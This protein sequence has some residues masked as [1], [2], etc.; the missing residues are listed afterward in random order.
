MGKARISGNNAF[1]YVT[2][3]SGAKIEIG[4]VDKFSAKKADEL[5]KAK[6][7]GQ[8]GIT[9]WVEH[10]G[11]ELS[12]E[13]GKVDFKL[14]QMLHAQDEQ[15]LKGGRSPYFKV[16]ERIEYMNGDIEEW[17][18]PEVS[19]HGYEID[20][21]SEELSEKFSGF[22]GVN[23]IATQSSTV[24]TGSSTTL[25]NKLLAAMAPKPEA[26]NSDATPTNG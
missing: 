17:E 22:C 11:W 23:R 8:K 6:P 18:Y 21:P 20:V 14:A 26:S 12:F 15:I 13:G 1:I 2:D 24:D 10:G 4:E 3:A 19:I 5:K 16:K 7:L 25:L 9:S